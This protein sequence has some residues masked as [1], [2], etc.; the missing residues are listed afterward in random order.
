MN[1][2]GYASRWGN[3]VIEIVVMQRAYMHVSAATSYYTVQPH[4]QD[5]LILAGTYTPR[6]YSPHVNQH[7]IHAFDKPLAPGS[8]SSG[9]L[10]DDDS[11][12]SLLK[13]AVM[14]VIHEVTMQDLLHYEN[15][16]VHQL[17]L[18]CNN[19]LEEW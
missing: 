12:T 17:L 16:T 11:D 9:A 5:H 10:S 19:L 15:S 6:I 7:R 3:G 4:N 18:E 8:V 14:K 2:K 13:R 1:V